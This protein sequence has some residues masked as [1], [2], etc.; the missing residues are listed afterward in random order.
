[1][2]HLTR[3][4][5]LAAASAAVAGAAAPR[6]FAREDRPVKASPVPAAVNQFGFDL[7]QRLAADRGNVFAS[8]FS[9]STAL[10]MTAAGARGTTLDEMLKVLHLPADAA[11]TDAGFR[12]LF[13]GVNGGRSAKRAYQLSTANAIWAQKGYP[14]R[15][16]FKDRVAGNYGAGLREADFASA[17]ESA[18]VAI[19]A[20]VEKETREKIKELLAKGTVDADTRM[21]LTNAVYFKGD[22]AAK[23]DKALTK[24]APFT[25]ADGT[26]ADVPLMHREGEYGYAEPAAGVQLLDLPYAGGELSMLVAL[27]RE[28]GGLDRV[29][30]SVS[31][32]ALAG[33][34]KSLRPSPVKVYLPRFKVET[35]YKLNDPL[36]ALGMKAAFEG[37]ADFSGMHTGPERLFISLV[38]HKAY[39]DVTE[40]GTEAAA[41]TGV[42]A[43]RVAAPVP[44]EP[45]VFRADRPFLF[46]IRDVK[47][48]A[49]LFLGRL[50]DPSR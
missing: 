35:E 1:V 11:A 49:V 45:V 5:F 25:A 13:D 23:F 46:L 8:P 38:V 37:S 28:A 36:K 2:N 33:W 21:V 9:V 32:D 42:V 29:A 17:H 26:K 14:W 16:E 24:D 18:R 6:L 40:E 10:A 3:R 44:R 27:P 48:G 15:P 50:T 39:A 12:A 20:W 43:K 30:K 41:A 34:V 22:W 7:Y 31:A 19:N 47:H 4:R